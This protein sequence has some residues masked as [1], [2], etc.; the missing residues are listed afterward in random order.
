MRV[1]SLLLMRALGSKAERFTEAAN[2]LLRREAE[3]Q[4]A[5]AR[6][7]RMAQG[8]GKITHFPLPFLEC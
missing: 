1:K 2:P 5:R 3:T 7:A 4:S 8:K 6:A